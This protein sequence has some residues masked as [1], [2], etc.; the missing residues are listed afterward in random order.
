MNKYVNSYTGLRAIAMLGVLFYHLLP[1]QVAGGYLGVLTF[2]AMAGFLGYLGL[3]ERMR[4]VKPSEMSK[5]INDEILHRVKRLLPELL[6]MV[7]SGMLFMLLFFPTSIKSN[8]LSAIG[9][10]GFINNITQ[11]FEGQSYFN[12]MGILKPFTHIWALGIEFQFHLMLCFLVFFC[13]AN[14]KK[15]FVGILLILLSMMSFFY[16][17]ML[18][19]SG[20]DMTVVYYNPFA[21]V[22]TYFLGALFGFFLTRMKSK[23]ADYSG[24]VSVF[25]LGFLVASFFVF[26]ISDFVFKY[27]FLAYSI[28]SAL[29]LFL[30]YHSNSMVSQ[31]LSTPILQEIGMRSYSLYLWHYPILKFM[32]KTFAHIGIP[33]FLYHILYLMIVIVISEISYR[34][35]QDFVPK[36]I[37]PKVRFSLAL[38][39]VVCVVLM[40]LMSFFNSEPTELDKMKETILENEKLMQEKNQQKAGKNLANENPQYSDLPSTEQ[41]D[42]EQGESQTQEAAQSQE[43]ASKMQV[44]VSKTSVNVAI[45]DFKILD[46]PSWNKLGELMPDFHFDKKLTNV[47]ILLYGKNYKQRETQFYDMF[48]RKPVEVEAPIPEPPVEKS[49]YHKK[50]DTYVEYANQFG[51]KVYMDIDKYAKYR[52]TKLLIIGDSIASMS[53]HTMALYMPE[54]TI[55]AEHSRQFTGA[56]DTYKKYLDQGDV[57]DFVVLALGT[58]GAVN[59]ADIDKV[60]EKLNGRKLILTSI[61]LPYKSEE[62]SRNKEIIAYADKYDD[63]YLV[64]WYG[65]AKNHDGWFFEDNIHPGENGA[66][67]YSQLIMRKIIEIMETQ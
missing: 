26:G 36:K 37:A 14:K 7:F 67:I 53:Y 50:A 15:R 23:I 66:K 25:I 38:G 20:A 1:D 32:D 63:V 12:Q 42:S 6:F 45:S 47:M 11:I 10:I 9:S 34:L 61:V 31:F 57:G 39:M 27:I 16:M 35:F 44:Q 46:T 21:R 64:D 51:D 48:K 33:A 24:V 60:H 56:Y 29:L 4:E 13:Y 18:S 65:I 17:Q 22:F 55:D 59:P 2:F 62:E 8:I 40:S 41:K 52:L 58:N 3:Y 30:L 43:K 28:A 49:V 5:L 19:G 54:A